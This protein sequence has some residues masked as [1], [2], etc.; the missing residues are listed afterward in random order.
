[1]DREILFELDEDALL[2]ANG[3]RSFS[4]TGVISV[5]ASHLS[6]KQLDGVKDHF[7]ADDK[8]LVRAIR[9]IE[10]DHY[11]DPIRVT[12]DF[13][14]ERET[15]HDYGGRFVWELLQNVDDAIGE[16][17]SSDVLIGSKGLGFKAVLEV[18]DE[19]EIHSGPFHFLFSATRTQELLKEQGLDADPP[20]LTFRIPHECEPDNR[21]RELLNAGYATVVRLPFRDEEK[22]RE[23]IDRL[24][25]LDPLFLLLAQELSCVRI[26]VPEGETVHDIE[27][28]EPGLSNGDV[29]LFTRGLNDSSSTSWRRWV[30]HGPAPSDDS[31][32]LTVAICL[33]LTEGGEAVPHSDNV[34]FH[35]FFPTEEKSGACALVHASFDLEHNR[36]RVRAGD[37]DADILQGF[38]ELFQDVLNDIPARTA[39]EAFGKIASEDGNS[40]LTRLQKKIRDTLTE[41]PFVPVI[42]GGRV[43]PGE[44]QL[45]QDRL[46]FVL[47]DEA[48][49]VRDACLLA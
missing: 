36:K 38:S 35:V 10:L 3:G 29:K 30:Q 40:P 13:N 18:T 34:P 2:V 26:R 16:G 24:R 7:K 37:D 44:V 1:M 6:D 14:N 39:L 31:K 11:K 8:Q 17:R 9:C 22:G 43:R 15:V 49:Q 32:Q 48:Q 28:S 21:V 46:G 5:C 12:S 19:P 47:R 41:T 20:P 45:W 25:A 23:V 27:R 33:P 4:R 42:G